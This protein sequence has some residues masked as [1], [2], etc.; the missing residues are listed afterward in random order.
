MTVSTDPNG[1]NNINVTTLMANL[2]GGNILIST[3]A[4]GPDAGNITISAGVTWGS[5]HTLTLQADNNININAPITALLG[6][7][8]IDAGADAPRPT[9]PA[10]SMS[11]RSPW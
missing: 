9:P 11:A 2:E 7:L 1:A 5:T 10:P 4:A 3:S 6:G 8:T